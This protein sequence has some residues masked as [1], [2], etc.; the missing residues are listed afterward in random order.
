MRKTIAAVKSK[1][2]A[3]YK[4]NAYNKPEVKGAVESYSIPN[5]GL[6]VW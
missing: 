5:I 6:Y 3:T 2:Y 4:K 1:I